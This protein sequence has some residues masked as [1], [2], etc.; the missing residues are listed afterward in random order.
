MFM[1]PSVMSKKYFDLLF[2]VT[3]FR[4]TPIMAIFMNIGVLFC[5][6]SIF[7]QTE[8]TLDSLNQAIEH[9]ESSSD[10]NSQSEIYID[11]LT[12]TA[13]V[14]KHS[15][16]DSLHIYA[17]KALQLSKKTDYV[18]GEIN[19]LLLLGYFHAYNGNATK[20]TENQQKAYELAVASDDRTLEL[21]A[22]YEIGIEYKNRS[23]YGK[24]LQ[25]LYLAIDL[26][27]NLDDKFHISRSKAH[28]AHMYRMHGYYEQ[29]LEVHKEILEINEKLG[30]D[31]ISN[32]SM[33]NLSIVYSKLGETEKALDYI[34]VAMKYAKNV[35]HKH[36]L[37]Y[38]YGVKGDI[39][40]DANN[41]KLALEWYEISQNSLTGIDDKRNS[42]AFLYGMAL[43]YFHLD[44]NEKAKS[45]AL[46]SLEL[47]EP[48]NLAI[49]L[50]ENYELLY[51]INTAE[52]NSSKALEYHVA[53]KKIADSTS[54][55]MNI[56]G[57]EILKAKMEF[58]KQKES[59]RLISDLEISKQK[60]F[61]YL[62]I[63]SVLILAYIIYLLISR[64]RERQKLLLEL[65]QSNQTKDKLFSVIGHD[66]KNPIM[67]LQQLLA[68]WKNKDVSDALL[69][70]YIP[71]L[72]VRVDAISFMLNNLLTWSSGQIEG[73]KKE[74][75][76]IELHELVIENI[77]FASSTI[78][79]KN[80]EVTNS[81]SPFCKIVADRVQ[82]DVILRNLL[83]N[84]LKFTPNNGNITFRSIEEPD[85][86]QVSVEDS[87]IGIEPDILEFLFKKTES[88]VS[89][90]GTN[91][92]PGTGIGLLLCKEMIENHGGT[93]RAESILGQGSTFYITIPKLK[94]T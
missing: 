17:E 62:G 50:E 4:Q 57:L 32:V 44:N 9:I 30:D 77:N 36:L 19:S 48:L 37:A 27:T 5:T 89:N 92:E 22:I 60:G 67:S 85:F 49:V 87:G 31:F 86:W 66:L 94:V 20:A 88:T 16:L 59:D 11:L 14:Y 39:Y 78:A 90:L 81:L 51:K 45:L 82:I 65:K 76:E 7:A 41:P 93:I 75:Q 71:K 12:N 28:I 47:A 21:K 56:N 40:E 3:S 24:A 29:S 83:N 15:K 58:E 35:D 53:F 54:R 91:K 13:S 33:A 10:F 1:V 61:T 73:G 79:K 80:I 26:A 70:A 64:S 18:R 63:V 43:A 72:S 55:Q 34:D 25:S 2:C 74:F 38:T 69:V 84:A 42:A 6:I 46:E 8:R 23:E 52:N 68:M